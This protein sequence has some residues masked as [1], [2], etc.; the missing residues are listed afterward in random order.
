[1]F[2][3]FLAFFSPKKSTI[4]WP[5]IFFCRKKKKIEKERHFSQFV[6]DMVKM[7][8][9]RKQNSIGRTKTRCSHFFSNF[10]SLWITFCLTVAETWYLQMLTTYMSTIWKRVKSTHPPFKGTYLPLF[11]HFWANIAFWKWQKS[12]FDKNSSFTL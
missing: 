9:L 12:K 7:N 6:F 2:S 3:N 11:T 1:M 5:Y 10:L 4:K 8:I